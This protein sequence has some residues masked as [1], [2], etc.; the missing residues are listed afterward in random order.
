L[1]D[2]SKTTTQV[3][4]DLEQL[5]F[6]LLLVKAACLAYQ[7]CF[8]DCSLIIGRT[9]KPG[10]DIA[11]YF[12]YQFLELKPEETLENAMQAIA[13][14]EKELKKHKNS[15]IAGDSRPKTRKTSTR[16]IQVSIDENED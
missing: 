14:L 1:P 11:E 6:N 3:W 15:P 9:N 4:H 8:E 13:I 12:L 5:Q 16:T 2:N 10:H 7:G